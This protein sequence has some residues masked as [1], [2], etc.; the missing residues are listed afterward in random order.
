[1][2]WPRRFV[3]LLA[4]IS[5]IICFAQTHHPARDPVQI[6]VTQATRDGRLADAEKLLTDAIREL[7]QSDPKNPRLANYL[8]S[9]SQFADRSGSPADAIALITRAYEIDRNAY[10]PSDLRVTN[11]LILLASHAQRT[12][13]TREAERLLNQA[14][15]IAR[16]NMNSL[17]S[18]SDVDL[19]AGVFGSVATLYVKEQRWSEAESLLREEAKLCNF[20]EE[21]YR[22]GYALCGSLAQRRAEVYRA[23]GRWVDADQVPENRGRPPELETLHKIAEKYEKDGLYPSAEDAYNR[24]IVLAEKIEADP[25][26]AYG[27][28]IV[29][30][31]NSLGQLFEKEGVNDRAESAYERA[32]EF[33]EMRAG[34][35]LGHSSYARM[36][37]FQFMLDLYRKQDRLM[38]AERVVQ[39]VLEIQER[40]LGRHRVV[41][42]TLMTLAG[43]YEEQG[44]NAEV[45]YS[46]A[47]SFY[48]RALAIQEANLGPSHPEVFDLLRK[49]AD[50][51]L[52]LH[53]DAKA[54]E[55]QARMAVIAHKNERN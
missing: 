24:A 7:E 11:D 22:E 14:L 4:I 6:A 44:R 45:N 15:E 48:Q 9:L 52:K 17:N 2:K 18:G 41:A 35:E 16:S 39:Q 54:A 8:K 40:S 12:G 32:L 49:C 21:P 50:L 51:L 33:N 1:M 53:D 27:D 10:G 43:L 42:Q 25:K 55:V 28:L 13:D 46:Q 5:P 29:T 47:L 19:A 3:P 26:N 34:P 23:E 38:D 20:F 31:I 30:E 36:L 37:N